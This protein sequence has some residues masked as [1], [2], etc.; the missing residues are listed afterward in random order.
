MLSASLDHKDEARVKSAIKKSHLGV[1]DFARKMQAMRCLVVEDDPGLGRVIQQGLREHGYAVDLIGD[2][3]EALELSRLEPYDLL[4]LDISL[5]GLSGLEICRRLRAHP[6]GATEGDTVPVLF[7]T[8][9]DAVPDRV[10]GLDAGGDDY[11][12]KPFDLSELLA[13]V[14]ALLRRQSA[15]RDPLLRVGDVSYDPGSRRCLA[16]DSPVDLTNKES[17]LLEYLLRNAGRVLTRDNIAAHVWDYDFSATSNVVDVYI[18]A[19]RR[20]LARDYIQTVRG[21]GYV[22]KSP[23]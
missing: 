4:V 15:T 17:Q 16:G 9:R 19:L 2:G 18:R 11:L 22:L 8:A 10:A 14:R 1:R 20:K 12:V 5:P 3:A 7:L 6:R 13:R 21:A 23:E